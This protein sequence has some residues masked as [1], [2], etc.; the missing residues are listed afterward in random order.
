MKSGHSVW[1]KY[2]EASETVDLHALFDDYWGSEH[3]EFTVLSQSLSPTS[4][5]VSD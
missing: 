3:R 5:R 2:R 1:T 4:P